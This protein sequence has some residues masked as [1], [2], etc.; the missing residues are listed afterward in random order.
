[1]PSVQYRDPFNATLLNS[2]ALLVTGE[3]EQYIREVLD[4]CSSD[5]QFALKAYNAIHH[6][7]TAEP[8]LPPTVTSLVPATAAVGDPSFTLQVMGTG[9]NPGSIIMFNGL[10]ENTTYVSPTE[11]STG[12]DM[13]VWLAAAVCP[14]SVMT[15]GVISD[16]MDFTFTDSGAGTLGAKSGKTE[17][18]KEEKSIFHPTPTVVKHEESKK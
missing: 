14:V 1:M 2:P 5:K 3:Q 7:L 17:V 4:V 6:I 8:V 12:V 11:V 15:N 18:K 13:S 10:N 16:P 9:F